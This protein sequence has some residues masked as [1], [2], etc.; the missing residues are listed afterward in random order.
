[1]RVI[2]ACPGRGPRRG[3]RVTFNSP[4][5]MAAFSSAAVI[6]SGRLVRVNCSTER[7]GGKPL[8]VCHHLQHLCL[9]DCGVVPADPI[10]SLPQ[11]PPDLTIGHATDEFIP[12]G[13]IGSAEFHTRF[14]SV[15]EELIVADPEGSIPGLVVCP[16][17]VGVAG[18]R[19]GGRLVLPYPTGN[20]TPRRGSGG[21]S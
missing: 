8:E 7:G 15:V 5:A 9:I 4:E 14:G 16:T 18:H 1:M 10:G 2:D 13:L 3:R 11:H 6:G 20:P 19:G 21:Q 12:R 17:V